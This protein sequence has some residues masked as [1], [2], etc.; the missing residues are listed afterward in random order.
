MPTIF[1]FTD[2]D[3]KICLQAQKVTRPFEKSASGYLTEN[4]SQSCR[5]LLSVRELRSTF[6]KNTEYSRCFFYLFQETTCFK[7]RKHTFCEN[8]TSRNHAFHSKGFK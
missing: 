8:S 2:F 1:F 6:L 7:K 5:E 4:F 3:V